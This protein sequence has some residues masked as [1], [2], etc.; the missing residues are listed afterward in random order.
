[1][2]ALCLASKAWSGLSLSTPEGCVYM[3]SWGQLS[4]CKN[5]RTYMSS[6]LLWVQRA[7]PKGLRMHKRNQA[8][9]TTRHDLRFA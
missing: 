8:F 7:E 9:C 4:E 3:D 5:Q 2:G 1:M 6:L